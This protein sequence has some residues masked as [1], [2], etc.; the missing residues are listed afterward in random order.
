MLRLNF[1]TIHYKHL[2]EPGMA[3]VVDFKKKKIEKMLVE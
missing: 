3:D 1:T 2:M